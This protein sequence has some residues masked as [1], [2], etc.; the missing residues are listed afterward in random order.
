[1]AIRPRKA[2][3]PAKKFVAPAK[4]IAAEWERNGLGAFSAFKVSDERVL[5]MYVAI[6]LIDGEQGQQKGEK[7]KTRKEY[8][9]MWFLFL[10]SIFSVGWAKWFFLYYSSFLP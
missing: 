1:M 9:Q 6:V 5:E 4:R 8:T 10:A 7:I 3:N 2:S